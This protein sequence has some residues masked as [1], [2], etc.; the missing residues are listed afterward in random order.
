MSTWMIEK[1]LMKQEEF[2][3]NLN[4]E[5]IQMQITCLQ[6]EFVKSLKKFR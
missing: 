6:K 5:D 3:C 1:G 2:H 4:T